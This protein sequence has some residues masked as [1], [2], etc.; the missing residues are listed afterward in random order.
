MNL[1]QINPLLNG[2]KAN[3]GT[4][5]RASSYLPQGHRKMAFPAVS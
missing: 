2:S 1:Q 5:Q 4:K 3:N